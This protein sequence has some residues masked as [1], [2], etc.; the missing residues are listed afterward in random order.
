[1]LVVDTSGSMSGTPLEQA[2][3]ALTASVD[4]LQPSDLT[5]LRSYGGGC[6]DGGRLLTQPAADNRD[7]LRSAIAGL[8][9]GG[10][11]PTP[12]A[13]TAGAG[14]LP[15]AA[16]QKLLIL[17]SDG[18]STCGSPC[19]VASQIKQQQG[20]NFRAYTVGFNA[21]GGA[22][23]ELQCIARVTG[24]QYFAASDTTTL[25]NAINAAIGSG[26]PA[27][28]IYGTGNPSSNA[29][30][31][32]AGDPVNCA[33]GNFTL[34]F[35][36]IAVAGRGPGLVLSRTYN[37][38][39]AASKGLF[40]HGWSSSYDMKLV[41]DATAGSVTVRQENG[42]EVVFTKT[43]AGDYTAPGWVL[44]T[45]TRSSDG[46]VLTRRKQQR[47]TFAANGALTSVSDLN[48]ESTDL[49]YA[50]GKL[51]SVRASG[52]RLRLTLDSAGRVTKVTGLMGRTIT[53]TYSDT[54]DL[55]AVR[56]PAGGTVR[57]GYDDKHRMT[58]WSDPLGART[59]NTYDND[60]RVIEQT[61]AL[62]ATTKWTYAGAAGNGTTTITGDDGRVVEE[63]FSGNLLVARTVAAGTPQAATVTYT[64]D[65]A[66]LGV[67][68]VTDPLGRRTVN[69]FDADGNLV[70]TTLP[71][72]S[73]TTNTYGELGNLTSATDPSGAT[74]KLTYDARGNLTSSTAPTA[75]GDAVT[76]YAHDD[77]RHPGD[78]TTVTD[79]EGRTT[80]FHYSSKGDLI[81]VT[82]PLGHA[83]TMR[84][85]RAGEVV[86]QRDADSLVTRIIRDELGQVVAVVGPAG[87]R[88]SWRYDAA[89][90]L[91]SERDPEGARTR[92]AYD[93]VGRLV[94][95]TLPDGA[96]E[97]WTYDTVGLLIREVDVTGR[98]ITHTYDQRGLPT[99]VTRPGGRTTS[100]VHDAAGQI[101]SVTDPANRTAAL[102]YTDN[103]ELSKID[104]ADAGTPDVS[105]TYD[106]NGMRAA[107]SDGTGTSRYSYDPSGQLTAYTN[108][109]GKQVGFTYDRSGLLTKLTYPG[110]HAVGYD[111]DAKGR[112]R[113]VT[114][115]R[116]KTFRLTYS[117]TDQLTGEVAPSGV[118]TRYRYGQDSLLAS[119]AV[120]D[121][122]GRRLLRL[123]NQRDR[124]GFVTRE[125]ARAGGSAMN[126]AFGYDAIGQLTQSTFRADP[127]RTLESTYDYRNGELQSV[128]TQGARRAEARRSTLTYIATTGELASQTTRI[129]GRPA[130]TTYAY[131]GLGQR[132]AATAGPIKATYGYD[133]SGAMTSY[134]GPVGG[135]GLASLE[136]DA[137]DT[138]HSRVASTAAQYTYD[139]DGLRASATIDGTTTRFTYNPLGSPASLLLAGDTA[140]VYGPGRRVLEQ[141]DLVN[142]GRAK[143][144]ATPNVLYLHADQLA[145]TRLVTDD[146]GRVRQRLSYTPFGQLRAGRHGHAPDTNI[147]FAGGYR[148][149]ES[150]LYYL[151][152]R[153]YDPATAQ[154]LT[155]DPL[156][157]LTGSAYGYSGN[158]P[159]NYTDPAGLCWGPGCWI[160]EKFP[161]ASQAIV[162]FSGGVLNGLTFGH[163]QTVLGWFGSAD[164]VNTCSGWYTGGELASWLL[165]GAA[166]KGIKAL[167]GARTVQSTTALV[168]YDADFALGQLTR[169]G[170]AKASQLVDFAE[171]QG[172]K[173]VQSQSGPIK[174]VDENGVERI[175][176]KKGSPRTPGS[177]D[178]HIAIR[179]A[180][181]QRVDPYGNPV[182]RRSPGNHTPIEWDLP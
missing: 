94:K 125:H 44:A 131:N 12:A 162:D 6:S 174:Y 176:I 132:S 103:S 165:P 129:G 114:D 68:T 101:I 172:W 85:N 52:R 86:R 19:P 99:S 15:A 17:V 63:R 80:R 154:F 93:A 166:L 24:G 40:G 16:L 161:R 113:A 124:R 65:P 35:T 111:H 37:S 73:T 49:H 150:G 146:K 21:P 102:S 39:D 120:S 119:V 144:K 29:S 2:K 20:V 134:H 136:A 87:S 83:T 105:F 100:F 5:G 135:Q 179:D 72:G 97:A 110:G 53:Y 159:L 118:R 167:R 182:S 133:Q 140:Y 59:T 51:R 67:A 10:G 175:V 121:E 26:V 128:L 90:R 163:G 28:A 62:G 152:N 115:W 38:L 33:T 143:S 155:I 109:A 145:S 8:T 69:E 9:A 54:G 108:G 148:D 22:E 30:V 95:I 48:G 58:S 107:M 91:V 116:G 89:G 181:G 96:S 55:T 60:G 1:M 77:T 82:D 147:L 104:Y 50:D 36:D 14:D 164:Y 88:S 31:A 141:L 27:S 153:Y 13:L 41:E 47:I 61:D 139:G 79:P 92:Y 170:R 106:A 57:F 66:T 42:S 11:T 7:Q 151:I 45:L 75:A 78:V 112:I 177:E 46:W 3:A 4:A 142:S 74:V 81:G 127:R 169:G 56:D 98:V 171:S 71:D 126:S 32:C 160:A 84:Y 34:P 23:D 25:Q 130:T 180:S 117:A 156:Q 178:P 18:Q 157:H 149:A 43:S 138:R 123:R 137:T 76:R 122:R 70:K 173:R 64:N 158:N 168:K